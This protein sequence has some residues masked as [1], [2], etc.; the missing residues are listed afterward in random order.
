MVRRHMHIIHRCF[1]SRH[2]HAR[3]GTYG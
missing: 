2:G 1:R 3:M